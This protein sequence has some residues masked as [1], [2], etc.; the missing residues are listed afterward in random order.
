[1]RQ[2]L[3]QLARWFGAVG[4]EVASQGDHVW[5]QSIAHIHAALNIIASGVGLQM[6]ITELGDAK[7]VKGWW[8]IGHGDL[9]TVDANSGTVNALPS[10]NVAR[11]SAAD[12][13]DK[14][15]PAQQP[16]TGIKI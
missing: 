6:Q 10:H 11:L 8:Q 4:D 12:S 16:T 13:G 1:L 14:E 15:E 3:R 7:A 5:L 9:H 2:D